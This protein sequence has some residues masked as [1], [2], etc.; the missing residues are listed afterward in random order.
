MLG[1]QYFRAGV[2][3]IIRRPDGRIL[4]LE[5]AD[6]PGAWQLPQGGLEKGEEPF[7]AILR[8]IAEETGIPPGSLTLA[9]QYPEPLAYELPPE[10]RSNKTGRGQAQYWFLFDYSGPAAIDLPVGGEFGSWRWMSFDEL[11]SK[12]VSFRRP[13]Y[14]KL[15]AYPEWGLVWC[16]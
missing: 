1:G 13:L 9:G 11:V 4:A 8:E 5:R 12:V 7:E 10:D 6:I 14:E 16:R 3:S 15:A 2:G